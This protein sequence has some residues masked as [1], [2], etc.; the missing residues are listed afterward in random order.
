MKWIKN[1]QRKGEKNIEKK[2]EK[3]IEIGTIGTEKSS[4]QE[5]FYMSNSYLCQQKRNLKKP[6]NLQE[7]S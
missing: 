2:S 4:D 6:K 5:I 7:V 3:K 1:W